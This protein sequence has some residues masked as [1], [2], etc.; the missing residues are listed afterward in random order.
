VIYAAQEGQRVAATPQAIGACPLCAAALIPKCGEIVTWHWAHRGTVECDAWHEHETEWH[1]QWKARAPAESVEVVMGPHR[2]DIVTPRAIIELQHSSISPAEIRERE[3]FY[4][5]RLI[6]LVDAI[7]AYREARLSVRPK[8]GYVTLRWKHPR[9]SLCTCRRPIWLDLG[10]KMLW[11]K[12]LYPEAPHG[13]WGYLCE[14]GQFIAR[15]VGR[16]PGEGAT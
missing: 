11:L 2:A 1:R 4:G 14:T 9:T 6:W 16:R 15:Y 5:P 8:K 10:T 7:E 3:A 12:R 13:G